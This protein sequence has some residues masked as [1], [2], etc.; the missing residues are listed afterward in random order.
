METK[1]DAAQLDPQGQANGDPPRFNL[2]DDGSI[3]HNPFFR[4]FQHERRYPIW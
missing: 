2:M 3:I 4:I 1:N